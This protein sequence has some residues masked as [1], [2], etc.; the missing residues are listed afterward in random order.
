MARLRCRALVPQR[1]YSGPHQ[2]EI[3]RGVRLVRWAP[4]PLTTR[5]IDGL[6]AHHRKRL[7]AGKTVSFA[8]RAP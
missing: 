5:V 2:C 6:C 8:P 4:T 3:R 1:T 7:E